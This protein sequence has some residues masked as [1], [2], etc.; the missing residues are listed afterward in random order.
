MKRKSIILAT[1]IALGLG[2]A[3]ITAAVLVPSNPAAAG[4]QN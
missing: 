4:G 2:T 3:F 1:L